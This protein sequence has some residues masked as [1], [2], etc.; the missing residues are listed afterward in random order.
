MADIYCVRCEQNGPEIEGL[1][2][3]AGVFGTDIRA[4]VCQ[5][6]WDEWS[7]MQIKVLNE[8]RLH[9]GEPSHRQQIQDYAYRFFRM[10][11]GDGDLG[12]GPEGG[13]TDE[14]EADGAVE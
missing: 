4:R 11:G 2:T 6:C 1:I 5:P 12:A 8:Y 9:M 14:A 3:F 10:D 13:L 7:E